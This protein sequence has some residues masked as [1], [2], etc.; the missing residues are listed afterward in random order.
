MYGNGLSIVSFEVKG[1]DFSGAVGTVKFRIQ[2]GRISDYLVHYIGERYG[3]GL[4][5]LLSRSLRLFG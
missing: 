2:R 3:L 4:W 1:H 5:V